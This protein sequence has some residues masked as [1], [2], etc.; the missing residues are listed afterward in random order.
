MPKATSLAA[1]SLSGIGRVCWLRLHPDR[2]EVLRYQ[3]GMPD[4]ASPRPNRSFA[5][6]AWYAG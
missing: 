6:S 4:K 1:P 3:Q 5:V 2:T